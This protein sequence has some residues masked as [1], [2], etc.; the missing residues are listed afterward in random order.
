MSLFDALE[1]AGYKGRLVSADHLKELEEEIESLR[2]RAEIDE[3]FYQARLASLKYEKPASMR[4][5]RSIIVIAVPQPMIQLSF[6]WEGSVIPVVL[7]PTYIDI[8]KINHTVRDLLRRGV[9]PERYRFVRAALPLKALAVH[10]GLALYGRNNIAYIPGYG[11]FHRL[12]AFFTDYPCR[13]DRWQAAR[14][15]AACQDCRDCIAACPTGAISGKRFPIRA[16]RCLTF[17][18]EKISGESFPAWVRPSW[19]HAI[20]GCMRCQEACVYNKKV[21]GWSERRDE[22]SEEET[23]YLM[24]GDFSGGMARRINRKLRRV[25]LDL[26]IF[27]RNLAVL[28]NRVK[29]HG[30]GQ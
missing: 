17:L 24:K 6:A 12:V 29:V 22:F 14:M 5:A 16:E 1:R 15:L 21:L 27:P 7:P 2:R 20:V 25:G 3:G 23:A 19:H 18:N 28:L 8:S 30:T 26:T 13:E 11:S 4:N 9:S 10:S